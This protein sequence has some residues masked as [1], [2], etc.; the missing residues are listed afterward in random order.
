MAK[1]AK[2]VFSSELPYEKDQ[3]VTLFLK[4]NF[5]QVDSF[6]MSLGQMTNIPPNR[7]RTYKDGKLVNEQVYAKNN[8]NKGGLPL[9]FYYIPK[10]LLIVVRD[11]LRALKSINFICDIFFAQHFLPAYIAVVLRKLG[12]LKCSKIIFWM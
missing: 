11:H 1:Y 10:S 5:K 8:L 6:I 3:V 2:C 12:I 4:D 7:L 9:Y